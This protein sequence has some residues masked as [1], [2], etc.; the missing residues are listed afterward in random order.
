MENYLTQVGQAQESGNEDLLAQLGG[1]I[2]ERLAAVATYLT[3][4]DSN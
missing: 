3:Q 2:D 1:S 4:L